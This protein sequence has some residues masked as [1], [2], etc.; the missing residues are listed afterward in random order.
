M[1]KLKNLGKPILRASHYPIGMNPHRLPLTFAVAKP[2]TLD[3]MEAVLAIARRGG[4]QLA[5]LQL[6]D[7]PD[8]S[9]VA[10]ELHAPEPELLDLFLARLHNLHDIDQITTP[11]TASMPGRWR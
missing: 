11:A 9:H 4:C 2:H 5:S 6:R 8:T 10:L 7:G 3:A 1:P